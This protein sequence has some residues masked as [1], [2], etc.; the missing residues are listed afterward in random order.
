MVFVWLFVGMT[1][2]FWVP[3]LWVR[4]IDDGYRWM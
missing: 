4:Y 2:G 1:I 3:R